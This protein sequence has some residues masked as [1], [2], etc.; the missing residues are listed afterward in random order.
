MNWKFV[1]HEANL[2]FSLS[3]MRIYILNLNSNYRRQQ[4]SKDETR[5]ERPETFVCNFTVLN[6]QPWFRFEFLCFGVQPLRK[7]EKFRAK[8]SIR[9]PSTNYT[10]FVRNIGSAYVRVTIIVFRLQWNF[11]YLTDY[12]TFIA[13]F[14]HFLWDLSLSCSL[15]LTFWCP[16]TALWV[17]G[18]APSLHHDYW[19]TPSPA[20]QIRLLD[21]GYRYPQSPTFRQV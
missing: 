16:A 20:L 21:S 17:H 1:Q 5:T 4:H 7:D 10:V 11:L 14:D 9:S 13:I 6:W 2:N 18:W 19:S 8:N 15:V 12:C 3:T